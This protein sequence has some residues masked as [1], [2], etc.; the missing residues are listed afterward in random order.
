M[1]QADG[2]LL[3]ERGG[4]SMSDFELLSL[5]F[6]V[7]FGLISTVGIIATVLLNV[8]CYI[9]KTILKKTTHPAKR[10]SLF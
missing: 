4:D 1:L 10:S 3:Q 2:Y 8:M 9:Q 7:L 5:V 6:T